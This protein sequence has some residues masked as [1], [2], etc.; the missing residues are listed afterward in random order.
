MELIKMGLH[1]MQNLGR[2]EFVTFP[3][4]LSIKEAQE[5]IWTVFARETKW[6]QGNLPQ[7]GNESARL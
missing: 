1:I 4:N 6:Q 2:G 7:Q 5:R 3:S